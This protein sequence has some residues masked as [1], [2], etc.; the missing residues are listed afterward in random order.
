MTGK[1]VD[2]LIKQQGTYEK[3]YYE[4]ILRSIAL[5]SLMFYNKMS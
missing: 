5:L 2:K 1:E 3:T 4:P